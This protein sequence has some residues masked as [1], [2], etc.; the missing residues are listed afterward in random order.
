MRNVI[1]RR[2]PRIGVFQ[3]DQHLRMLVVALRLHAAVQ[4]PGRPSG[5][6]APRPK[7]DSKKSLNICASSK[8]PRPL[9]SNPP[10]GVPAPPAE[11]EVLSAFMAAAASS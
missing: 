7:I 8:P 2:A 4:P 5:A 9:K 3:V 10:G 1:V 6:R 11:L